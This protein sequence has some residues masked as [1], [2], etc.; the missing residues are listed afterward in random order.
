MARPESEKPP[1]PS[2]PPPSPAVLVLDRPVTRAEVERLCERL[3][4]LARRAGPGPVT[5][6][7]GGVGRP[8][9]AVLEALARLRLTAGRLG[10]GIQ[11]R[12]ACGEL[13][14]LLAW[15]GLD[16]ALTAPAAPG[17][18]PGSGHALGLELGGEAEQREEALGVQEGV[19]P[20][21]P[22]P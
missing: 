15:T 8:D 9:L 4:A 13:R 21:D 2:P 1:T 7:V 10:R 14:R 20:G 19:E 3:S 6:D 16:E 17:H 22:A 18:P 5:V 12:N 11:L